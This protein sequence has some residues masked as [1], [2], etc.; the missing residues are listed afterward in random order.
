MKLTIIETGQAPLA[1]RS[2]FPD[3]PAMF[4]AM[5]EGADPSIRCETVSLVTGAALPAPASLEAV[6]YTGSPAGVYEDHAWITPLMDFIRAAADARTPQIGI[7]FGHQAMAEAL[8]GKVQKSEKGWGVGRHTYDL[9]S[10]PG[11]NGEKPA[12]LSIAVSHQD[13]VVIRPP[14]AETI[15]RSEF[16]EFAA[17][18]YPEIRGL[19]FQCHPEF[20][21]EFAAALYGARRGTSLPAETA[22]AAIASLK[23]GCDR[24]FLADWIASFLKSAR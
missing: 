20:D 1:I 19:S 3:Y 24:R 14:G 10:V 13:Q 22:D 6:L 11:W 5:F 18:H 12:T 15:A 21:A 7:C 8:G 17:L 4:S 16:T 23:E 2:Q 9:L